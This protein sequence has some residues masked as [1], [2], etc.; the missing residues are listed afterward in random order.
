MMNQDRIINETYECKNELEARIY[1]YR[2]K[3][4]DKWAQH[5]KDQESLNSFLDE[6]ENW[7]YDEGRNTKKKIYQKYLKEVEEKFKPIIEIYF[8][9]QTIP[10]RL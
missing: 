6:K 8:I 2:E 7:L 4:S 10:Q 5:T 9:Y 3:L 1:D